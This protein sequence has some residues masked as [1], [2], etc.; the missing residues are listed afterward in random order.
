[1]SE[2]IGCCC[3]QRPHIH[4]C[5][6]FIYRIAFTYSIREKRVIFQFFLCSVLLF[7]L[8]PL[9][10]PLA[11]ILSTPFFIFEQKMRVWI[12]RWNA[13]SASR[14]Y[15]SSTNKTVTVVFKNAVLT[16]LS[17]LLAAVWCGMVCC[18]RSFVFMPFALDSSK[19][20]HKQVCSCA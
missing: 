20:A 19:V 11:P 9:P 13:L 6:S 17:L 16:Q 4:P 8:L 12:Y 2:C 1:M 7:L 5:T 3:L 10:P 15:Y 14:A 18:V